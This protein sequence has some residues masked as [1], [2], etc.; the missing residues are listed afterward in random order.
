MQSVDFASRL[1][2]KHATNYSFQ[3]SRVPNVNLLG[4]T[5]IYEVGSIHFPD[6]DF[7]AYV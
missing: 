3:C 1:S 6:L 7:L 5:L 4:V 2:T